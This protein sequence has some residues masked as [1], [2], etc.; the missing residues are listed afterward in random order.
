MIFD[1]FP[2]RRFFH[3]INKLYHYLQRRR[4]QRQTRHAIRR[5][6][7]QTL[8]DIGLTKYDINRWK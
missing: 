2:F 4:L 5:L 1:K 6:N 3:G 7:E 8:K